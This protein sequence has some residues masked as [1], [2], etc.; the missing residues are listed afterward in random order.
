MAR[1]LVVGCGYVGG[2]LAAELARDD[3]EVWGLRRRPDEVPESVRGIGGDV[4]RPSTLRKLPGDL[5]LV[6]YAVSPDE[7]AEAA[8]RNAYVQ[9]LRNLL[10]SLEAGG[11]MPSRLLFVSSTAVYGQTEGEWVDESSPT[12]PRAFRGG[13]VLEGEAL[14]RQVPTGST[15]LRLGGIY[16]PGRTRLVERVRRGEA[17]CPPDPPVYANR[18]HR[19][20]AAGM[21]LHLAQLDDP[22]ELY[23]GVDLDPAP[24][25]QVLRWLA[26][27]TGSPE[28]PRAEESA[29]GDRTNKRCSSERIRATGYSL[30]YPT[31]R[32]GYGKLLAE[33]DG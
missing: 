22:D 4:S 10:D 8:Y 27:R 33:T 11:G 29:G 23:L 12:E 5:D 13:I 1:A 24:R 31:F 7:R 20:D 6:V 3:W 28:P 2:Q 15:V 26:R 25:C 14:A 17:R 19:D 16:G 21:L 32:E 18:I 30:R 9:G